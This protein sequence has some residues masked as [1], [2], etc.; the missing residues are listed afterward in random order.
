MPQDYYKKLQLD[1][2]PV[3]YLSKAGEKRNY[4]KPIP[5]SQPQFQLSRNAAS[6]PLLIWRDNG[7]TPAF[8]FSLTKPNFLLNW[9]NP[10]ETFLQLLNPK[11]ENSLQPIQAVSLLFA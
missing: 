11:S 5:L 2:S 1:L 8:G 3:A 9:M 6:N 4:R 10:H 7:E